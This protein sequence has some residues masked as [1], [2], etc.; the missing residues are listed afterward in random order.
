MKTQELIELLQFNSEYER[1]KDE[2]VRP[3]GWTSDYT[4]GY[5][6]GLLRA[7]EIIEE[8]WHE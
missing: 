1:N 5:A 8:Q 3:E 6:D 2:A 7:V 4:N